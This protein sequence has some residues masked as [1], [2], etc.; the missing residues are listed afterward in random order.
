MQCCTMRLEITQGESWWTSALFPPW[1]YNLKTTNLTTNLKWVKNLIS[2][3]STGNLENIY[4]GSLLKGEERVY[5]FKRHSM[6]QMFQH[7]TIPDDRKSSGRLP[8]GNE[9]LK[10]A[11]GTSVKLLTTC[12]GQP[13]PVSCTV[14]CISG[15]EW[16]NRSLFL[17][18]RS[19]SK[20]C[21]KDTELPQTWENEAK[22]YILCPSPQNTIHIKKQ[23]GQ[24]ITLLDCFSSAMKH[25]ILRCD[26]WLQIWKYLETQPTDISQN[27]EDE[28]FHLPTNPNPI[29]IQSMHK[30]Q[31]GNG[32]TKWKSTCLNGP[33]LNIIES[34]WNES[35][36][37]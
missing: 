29:T 20:F 35:T 34:L 1:P 3:R 31:Q 27:A 21:K 26:K 36:A 37:Q 15:C 10:R 22:R 30:G 19:P 4:R 17:L 11:G 14:T 25:A 6:H 24:S 13:Y 32:F 2:F 5:I 8:R 12:M 23:G 18:T 9:I 7:Q 28:H 33:D 16:Q